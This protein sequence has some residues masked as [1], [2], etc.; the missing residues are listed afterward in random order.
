[1]ARLP[2]TLQANLTLACY[3]IV[4]TEFATFHNPSMRGK[5]FS[6]DKFPE[7]MEG[8]GWRNCWMTVTIPDRHKEAAETF[9]RDLSKKIAQNLVWAMSN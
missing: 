2:K 3:A 7:M 4:S 9:A 6:W 8:S 1:M 5:N